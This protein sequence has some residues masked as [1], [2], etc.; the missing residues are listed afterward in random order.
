MPGDA[1]DTILL[2]DTMQRMTEA[3]KEQSRAQSRLV[4]M[5]GVV[6]AALLLALA[7]GGGYL[8]GALAEVRARHDTALAA[9]IAQADEARRTSNRVEEKLRDL[10]KRLPTSP[11]GRHGQD[12]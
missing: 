11:D 3:A 6:G 4:W 5:V 12:Q 9:A 1:I 2:R 10:R 8:S 7:L